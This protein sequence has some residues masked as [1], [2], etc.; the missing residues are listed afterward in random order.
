MN[1]TRLRGARLEAPS[2]IAAAHAAAD[3]ADSHRGRLGGSRTF[4]SLGNPDF[5]ML[6]IGLLFSQ[7]AMQINI[8]ARSWLA[9]EV[10]GSAAVLGLVALAQALPM[11]VLSLV[12]GALADRMDKRLILVIVQGGL[13]LLALITAVL[14][15]LD[16][17]VVWHLVVVG[18][19]Q[20]ATF[21]FSVPARQALIP[22]LVEEDEVRNAIAMNSTGLNVTRVI[23]PA[24][25]GILM[26][27]HPALA[28]DAIAALYLAAALLLFRLPK[29]RQAPVADRKSPVQ[30]VLD[31]FRYVQK[32]PALRALMILAF[33]PILL[34]MPFQQFMPVFQ[35]DVLHVS[36]FSLGIMFTAVGIG[37]LAGSLAVAR[38]AS[39]PRLP[40][41]QTGSGFLFGASLVA[42]AL[43]PVF[44]LSLVCLVV[45]GV[46]SQGYM[47]MNSVLIMSHTEHHYFGRVMSIYMITFSLMPLAVLPMGFLIDAVGVSITQAGAGGLLAAFVLVYAAS[48]Q[49]V[50]RPAESPRVAKP[51]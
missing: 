31:G 36:E 9:Y 43:S 23:G 17:V 42:F 2:L 26:A 12:G 8:I 33:I 21:A 49:L 28:F 5:R 50:S 30:E 3:A 25:A 1:H 6:W 37:S 51:V 34:G 38:L 27:I 47:T 44:A 13:A 41:L 7:G 10:S 45:V 18:L 11:G 46:A 16:I 35:K 29:E 14:V 48:K 22:S 4:S 39:S 19:L 40:A 15:H 24:I 32:S 20:G